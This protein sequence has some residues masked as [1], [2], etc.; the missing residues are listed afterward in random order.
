MGRARNGCYLLF[1]QTRKTSAVILVSPMTAL[2][3]FWEIHLSVS[4]GEPESQAPFRFIIK[5]HFITCHCCI[6]CFDDN[7]IPVRY[8]INLARNG[9]RHIINNYQSEDHKHSRQCQ[10]LGSNRWFFE[11]NM[12]IDMWKVWDNHSAINYQGIERFQ[13]FTYCVTLYHFFIKHAD[14]SDFREVGTTPIC[15]PRTLK[16][17]WILV[18]LWKKKGRLSTRLSSGC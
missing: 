15:S 12:I 11:N 6:G 14:T 10:L 9:V 13:I 1:A 8:S 18:V 4:A 17:C 3:K 5:K 2:V 7:I 16:Y